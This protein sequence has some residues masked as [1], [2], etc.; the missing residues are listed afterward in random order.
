[1]IAMIPGNLLAYS[2]QIAILTGVAAALVAVLKLAAPARLRCLQLLLACCLALPLMQPWRILPAKGSVTISTV[3]LAK[4]P[5]DPSQHRSWTFSPEIA[6]AAI[7]AA[8]IAVRLAMVGLGMLRLRRYIH[9]AR[10]I[11]AA[12]AF[13][14]RRVGAW[15][16]VFVSDELKGPVTFGYF[17]PA[18]L[19]PARWIENQTIAYHELLHVRRSDW[20]FMMAEEFVRALLWFHP[21]VW[22]L[23]AQIQLAREEVVDREA[24]Q[25]IESREQYLDTLLAIAEANAGLDL[26][27]APLFLKKRRLRQRVAALL[28]EVSMSKIRM[29]SSIAG[30]T[31]LLGAAGWLAVRSF[32]LQAAPQS[33]KDAP[34]VTVQADQ[35]KLL[36][37]APVFYPEAALKKGV[38]GT[39]LVQATLGDDGAVTDAQVIS[40]PPELRKAAL[41]SVLQWHYDKDLA[42]GSTVRIP[43]DFAL[44]AGGAANRALSTTGL[45]GPIANIDLSRLPEPLRDKVAARLPVHVGDNFDAQ[46][47]A[48]LSAALEAIDEHLEPIIGRTHDGGIV[49][50]AALMTTPRDNSVVRRIRVGGNAQ[51]TNLLERVIPIYPPEAK[52]QRI[53]GTVRFTATIGK[54]GHVM[55]LDVMSGDPILAKAAMEAVQQWIYRPALLNGNPVEVVTQID[56]NFTLSN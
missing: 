31:L 10:L 18:I 32:P 26:L 49:V 16:D 27:P 34:G 3:V 50:G 53:Q 44:P 20:A 4:G 8:G 42:P 33:V 46:S 54:D 48:N 19:I 56:V 28:K 2:I 40:G 37:R 11:P 52:Q 30:F 45:N 17:R 23:I 7:L 12:L 6:I 38:Q 43:I 15:P 51:A 1:M 21:A 5:A 35:S 39:V 29:R 22:W 24:V 36:H 25:L 47:M 9:G 41:E 14:K 55:N 13:E